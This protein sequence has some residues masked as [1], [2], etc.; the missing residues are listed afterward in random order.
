MDV[1]LDYCF[2]AMG[3]SAGFKSKFVQA[4]RLMPNWV[5]KE[6]VVLSMRLR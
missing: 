2:D 1:F 5:C 4:V 6:V 3:L